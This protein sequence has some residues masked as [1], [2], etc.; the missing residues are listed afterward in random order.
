MHQGGVRRAVLW[1]Y[2][3]STGSGFLGAAVVVFFVLTMAVLAVSDWWLA[4][5]MDETKGGRDGRGLGF[6]LGM[7]VAISL[8]A[9]LTT[10]LR[11]MGILQMSVRA[12]KSLHD[13][14]FVSVLK[15][16]IAFFDTT[17]VGINAPVYPS[18]HQPG[19]QS[20]N[21]PIGPPINQSINQPVDEYI[22]QPINVFNI[23][24][25]AHH[26][27]KAFINQS[28]HASAKSIEGHLLRRAATVSGFGFLPQ[29]PKRLV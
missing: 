1:K 23:H 5:W 7:Y 19:N 20:M 2:L 8:S 29:R 21:Q 18:I 27:I 9:A 12:S 14:M 11:Q 17:P 4:Y 22:V 13:E 16:P 3:H 24:Q 28:M 10:Y 26:S 15:C 6:Y 25:G